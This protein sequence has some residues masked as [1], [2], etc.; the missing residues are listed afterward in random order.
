MWNRERCDS[1]RDS[2]CIGTTSNLLEQISNVSLYAAYSSISSANPSA[3]YLS[4]DPRQLATATPTASSNPEAVD[5]GHLS[6][7]AIGGIVA[8]V[9]V[10]V[11]LLSMNIWLFVDRSNRKRKSALG[12]N[13]TR[14]TRELAD[15]K[16]DLPVGGQGQP[17]PRVMRRDHS[18][19]PGNRDPIE[20]QSNLDIQ[21]LMDGRH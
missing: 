4:F 14:G 7:A 5:S 9:V 17:D 1:R 21:E 3:S 13:G 20:L 11:I 16:A 19:L 10:G 12:T 15:Q 18:E 2:S 8:G 6:G